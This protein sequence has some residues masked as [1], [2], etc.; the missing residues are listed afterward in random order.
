MV[1]EWLEDIGAGDLMPRIDAVIAKED[2]WSFSYIRD[3]TGGVSYGGF[4]HKL[5]ADSGRNLGI[6]ATESSADT[7]SL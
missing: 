3:I 7:A 4:P 2:R 5:T 6:T 1:D